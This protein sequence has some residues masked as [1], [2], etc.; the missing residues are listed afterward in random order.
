MG[1][2]WAGGGWSN[3]EADGVVK[4]GLIVCFREAVYV[5]IL[6]SPPL[7]GCEF[8]CV[9]FNMILISKFQG[10]KA[11][12]SAGSTKIL[13]SPDHK[14]LKQVSWLQ[15]PWYHVIE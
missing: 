11:E 8:G 12:I 13:V 14:K 9:V 1:V 3:C 4:G 6:A 10:F 7:N 15:S 2:S 5:G